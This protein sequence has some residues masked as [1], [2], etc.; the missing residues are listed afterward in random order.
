MTVS[1]CHNSAINR[2]VGNPLPRDRG[3]TMVNIYYIHNGEKVYVT[4]NARRT[5]ELETLLEMTGYT[6]ATEHGYKTVYMETV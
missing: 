6:I 1:T 2:D 4:K 5:A 3:N